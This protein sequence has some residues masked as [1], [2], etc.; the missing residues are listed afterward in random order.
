MQSLSLPRSHFT[1]DICSAVHGRDHAAVLS[2]MVGRLEPDLYQRLYEGPGF[3]AYCSRAHFNYIS[4]GH[5]AALIRFQL[6]SGTSMSQ[7][8]DS[9][10]RT[11]LAMTER[12]AYVQ[13]ASSQT[14]QSPYSMC[15]CIALHMSIARQLCTQRLPLYQRHRPPL[16]FSLM[17]RGSLPS[18]GM[19]AWQVHSRHL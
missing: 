5:Q 15:C 11:N 10:S 1:P 12:I 6:R 2:V 8:H 17:M 14:A 7:Q 18:R 3:R 19:I 13:P 4:C 16:Q 9:R